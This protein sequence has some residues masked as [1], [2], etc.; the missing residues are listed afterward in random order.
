MAQVVHMK[1][2]TEIPKLELECL[3][4]ENTLTPLQI[5]DATLLS[6]IY[7]IHSP[8]W[9]QL[10]QLLLVFFVFCFLIL[11]AHQVCMIPMSLN[12]GN[13]RCDIKLSRTQFTECQ[14]QQ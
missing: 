12:R 7:S 10:A 3:H 14:S 11:W 2:E 6:M 9:N 8:Y 4:S 1:S 13:V 5:L